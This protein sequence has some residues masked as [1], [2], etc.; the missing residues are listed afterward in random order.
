MQGELTAGIGAYRSLYGNIL[1]EAYCPNGLVDEDEMLLMDRN[2]S[3][4]LVQY[5]EVP[6]DE[7]KGFRTITMY[8]KNN[9]W[10]PM[11]KRYS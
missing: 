5:R 3:T 1:E 9:S 4:S 10:L 8:G 2:S 7:P 11:N 6:A